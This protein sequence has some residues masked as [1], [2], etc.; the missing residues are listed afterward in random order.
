MLP[1]KILFNLVLFERP[2][3]GP[4][5]ARFSSCERALNA[6]E[7]YASAIN[8]GRLV[9]RKFAFTAAKE[10]NI[11]FIRPTTFSVDPQYQI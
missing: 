1:R 11:G 5:T 6:G 7:S 9:T 3:S 10:P 8:S 4:R 2:V